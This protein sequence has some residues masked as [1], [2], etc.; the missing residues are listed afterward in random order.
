MKHYELQPLDRAKIVAILC[1]VV[2]EL[3]GGDPA[4]DR[5]TANAVQ[6]IVALCCR[7]GNV[8]EWDRALRLL[9]QDWLFTVR[10]ISSDFQMEA[11]FGHEMKGAALEKSVRWI[12]KN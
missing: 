10:K 4:D 6:A 1:R 3:A 8:R 9:E 2:S 12:E 11:T 5:E 7:R